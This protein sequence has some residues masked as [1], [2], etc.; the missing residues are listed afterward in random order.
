M[1][2]LGCPMAPGLLYQSGSDPACR[3]FR[4]TTPR[5]VGRTVSYPFV[6]IIHL[7]WM[8]QLYTI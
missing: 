3:Y 7:V 6:P 8:N 2:P 5:W 4:C 1:D